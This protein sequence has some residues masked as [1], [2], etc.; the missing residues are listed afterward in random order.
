METFFHSMKAETI[1]GHIFTQDGL[2]QI[3]SN[4]DNAHDFPSRGVDEIEKFDHGTF[5]VECGNFATATRRGS[6]FHSLDP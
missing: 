5:D 2:G 1:H 6:P 3:N 4:D